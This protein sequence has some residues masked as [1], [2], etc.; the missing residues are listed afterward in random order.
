MITIQG[1]YNAANVMID[2]IDDTTRSQIQGCVTCGKHGS[3][4]RDAWREG[5]EWTSEVSTDS[6]NLE[7]LVYLALT[8]PDPIISISRGR[9]LLGFTYMEEMREWMR[10]YNGEERVQEKGAGIGGPE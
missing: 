4:L 6:T 2:T 10:S 9:E 1:K 3:C 5:K 8:S 7:W